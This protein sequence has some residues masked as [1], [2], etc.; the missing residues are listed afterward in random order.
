[1]SVLERRETQALKRRLLRARDQ[2]L[3]SAR[4]ELERITDHPMRELAGEVGDFADEAVATELADFD[5]AM[6]Q[7][8]FAHVRDIDAAL[9]R[10]GERQYGV[11]ADCGDAIAFE[12]LCAFPTALR[13]V[14]C[15]DKHE[16][17]YRSDLHPTL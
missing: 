3:A 15:Q 11:C 2:A 13:C 9:K 16:R 17:T 6:I 8:N 10:I 5:N 14:R 4:E 1:M 7:R 12:R